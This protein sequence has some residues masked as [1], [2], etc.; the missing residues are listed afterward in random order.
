M[1]KLKRHAYTALCLSL[2]GV[3]FTVIM[4]APVIAQENYDISIVDDESVHVPDEYEV[5]EG[6]TLW[7]ISQEFFQDPWLWPNLWA[8]N[9]HITNPH[10]IYPGDLIRLKWNPRIQRN[11]N[12]DLA[13]KPVGYSADLKKVVQKVINKGM[14]V[15]SKSPKI[16][17]LVASPE[18]KTNLATG[19]IAYIKIEDISR[20]QLNQRLSIYRPTQNVIHPDHKKV[21]GQKVLLV[22]TVEVIEKGS[23]NRLVKVK[24]IQSHQEIE[25]GDLIVAEVPSLVE[26]N[27]VK[28]LV[29]LEG[30]ILDGLQDFSE[31]AQHHVIFLDVGQKDGVQIG[32]RLSVIRQGDGLLR[33]NEKDDREMPIEAIGEVLIIATQQ[34]TSTALITR[35]KLE[36]RKGDQVL[37][38]RNY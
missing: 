18:A 1:Y 37:M 16:G 13:L 14:I 3:L 21:V 11:N 6:D 24:I 4:I 10:W 15:E 32:N 27:P 22:G 35:S 31:F 34:Q 7:L 5:E 8:L 12:N 30:V 25:R 19:D 23:R 33:L 29:D 9:P 20:L 28:N 38:L 2:C 17:I 36:L 26:I